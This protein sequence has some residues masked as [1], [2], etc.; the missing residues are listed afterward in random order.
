MPNT[1]RYMPAST[2]IVLRRYIDDFYGRKPFFTGAPI[3]W[4]SIARG[5]I[6]IAWLRRRIDDLDV[7]NNSA[8]ARRMIV[9]IECMLAELALMETAGS[10]DGISGEYNDGQ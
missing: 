10:T 2:W 4:C 7:P 3:A 9:K 8:Y 1:H 6:I 5:G